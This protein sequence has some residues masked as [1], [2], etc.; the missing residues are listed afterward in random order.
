[1]T[2]GVTAPVAVGADRV[3]ENPRQAPCGSDPRPQCEASSADD[4]LSCGNGLPIREYQGDRR[5]L[6]LTPT[7]TSAATALTHPFHIRGCAPLDPRS[8]TPR[9]APSL[10]AWP[11]AERAARRGA[12][13]ICCRGAVLARC[14][15]P[16][17]TKAQIAALQERGSRGAQPLGSKPAGLRQLKNSSKGG[18]A[19]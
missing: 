8:W 11:L 2:S 7:A 6:R 10:S 12:V 5:R 16:R 14:N 18:R 19:R 13:G 9:S 15:T 17:M 4:S 1:M 3:A